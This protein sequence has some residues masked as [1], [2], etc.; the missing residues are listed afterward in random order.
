MG[1]QSIGE[2]PLGVEKLGAG[3]VKPGKAAAGVAGLPDAAAR[4]ARRDALVS[5]VRSAGPGAC[6]GAPGAPATAQEIQ[7]W[8]GAALGN[9]F[10]KAIECYS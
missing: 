3:V 2:S 10:Q 6:D 1:E 5:G 8:Q 9:A 7:S 4:A